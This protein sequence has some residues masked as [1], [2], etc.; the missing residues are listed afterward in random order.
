MN[1]EALTTWFV[2]EAG[3]TTLFGRYGKVLARTDAVS[4]FFMVARLE[5]VDID[6]LQSDMDA[7]RLELLADPFLKTVPSMQESAGKTA[8]FF[9]AKDDVPEVR[10]A[11][12]KL[13]LRHDLRLSAVVKEKQHLLA[14]VHRHQAINPKYR[15][16]ADGHDIYDDLIAK[17]FG[18]FGEFGVQRRITFA[19][20][21]SKPRTAALKTVL[22]NIDEGFKGDFGFAPHGHTTVHSG[23]PSASAGLQACDYLLWALQRFC[24]RA[25]ERYLHAMWPKFTQVL[26]LD[27]PAPKTKGKP[28]PVGVAFNENTR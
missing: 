9:H 15:Y 22:D 5:V 28:L 20:R 1:E 14:E 23:Y 25:E 27:A 12:F 6:A 19:V 10:H 18:R 11:V 21:G 24:E 4:H 3:D 16:K 2:D 13:L 26:D 7:L 17:L 8:L